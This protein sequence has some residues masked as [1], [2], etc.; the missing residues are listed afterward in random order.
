MYQRVNSP[1]PG[2]RYPPAKMTG[3]KALSALSLGSVRNVGEPPRGRQAAPQVSRRNALLA[4]LLERQTVRPLHPRCRGAQELTEGSDDPCLPPPGGADA[5]LLA[6]V[7]SRAPLP[8]SLH[9]RTG[10]CKRSTAPRLPRI[11]PS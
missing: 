1:S 4:D 3:G 7:T 10:E 11:R 8:R 2:L 5:P 9:R 6:I